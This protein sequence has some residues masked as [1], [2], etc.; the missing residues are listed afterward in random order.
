MSEK[1]TWMIGFKNGLSLAGIGVLPLVMG[2]CAG[3]APRPA[4][5][6]TQDQGRSNADKAFEKLK[7]EEKN[8]AIDSRVGPY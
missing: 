8:R 4:P 1:A 7:Q 6:M 2:G 5:T 3:E